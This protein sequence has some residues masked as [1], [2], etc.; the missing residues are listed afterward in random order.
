MLQHGSETCSRLSV[1]QYP[2]Y[3]TQAH[4]PVI[5]PFQSS[6]KASVPRAT[7]GGDYRTAFAAAFWFEATF[8]SVFW[9][10]LMLPRT[11]AHAL[12]ISVCQNARSDHPWG[13]CV[14]VIATLSVVLS[15]TQTHPSYHQSTTDSHWHA[16]RRCSCHSDVAA[17][18]ILAGGWASCRLLRP[19][20]LNELYEIVR[21]TQMHTSH[22][23]SSLFDILGENLCSWK[24]CPALVS[25]EEEEEEEGGAACAWWLD[26]R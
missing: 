6:F 16:W 22:K 4:S 17:P 3:R 24:R 1:T 11:R 12:T 23:S 7:N 2:C 5:K 10:K 8:L 19:A 13:V 25:E 15:S 26:N 21:Q 18:V 20:T 14:I 9:F